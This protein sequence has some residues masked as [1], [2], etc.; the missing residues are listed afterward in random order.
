MSNKAKFYKNRK[1]RKFKGMTKLRQALP[2]VINVR[3]ENGK[4]VGE[5]VHG[6]SAGSLVTSHSLGDLPP[7][8]IDLTWVVGMDFNFEPTS[9]RD[10][11]IC[12][13]CTHDPRLHSRDGECK[14]EDH[15]RRKGE[16]CKNF[17]DMSFVDVSNDPLCRQ[18]TTGSL[19]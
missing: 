13:N 9:P 8:K 17:R 4:A 3:W 5:L 6:R 14:H 1:L 2:G 12:N 16:M 7:P 15:S 10:P 11:E 19:R 18:W